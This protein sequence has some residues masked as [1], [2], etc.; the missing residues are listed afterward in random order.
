[1]TGNG[2]L[3]IDAEAALRRCVVRSMS[4][5]SYEGERVLAALLL[6]QHRFGEAVQIATRLSALG[7]GA[8]WLHGVLGDAG[9]G[10]G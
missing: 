8:A 6:S 9:A 5:T 3:V 4:R 7:P 10:T 1:M 2:G